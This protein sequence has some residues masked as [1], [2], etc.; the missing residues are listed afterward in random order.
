MQNVLCLRNKTDNIMK[1]I[2]LKR[3]Y[4]DPEPSDGFRIFVDRLWPRGVRKAALLYD[5]WAKDI[6]P[7]PSLRQWFHEDSDSHWEIF[8]ALYRQ[9]LEASPAVESFLKT[10]AEYPVITLLFASKSVNH[11]HAIILKDFLDKRCNP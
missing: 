2:Q 4:Q 5:L 1:R 3:V 10:I 7:S 9:E 8:R 6:T 11:N